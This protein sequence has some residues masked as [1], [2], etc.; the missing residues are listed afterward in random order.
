MSNGLPTYSV[1]IEWENARLSELGRTREMLKALREQIAQSEHP[2]PETII[3]HDKEHVG[4]Q[5][6]EDIIGE[7][8]KL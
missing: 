6:I 2:R 3:L 5:L 8:C 7:A 4:R 1:V